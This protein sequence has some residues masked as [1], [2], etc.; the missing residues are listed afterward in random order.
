M[1]SPQI[2]V[3]HRRLHRLGP[4]LLTLLLLAGC[5]SVEVDA[6]DLTSP[7]LETPLDGQT[8]RVGTTIT[9]SWQAVAGASRYECQVRQSDDDGKSVTTEYTDQT[10]VQLTFNVPGFYSWRV[11]AM[12]AEDE[13]GYWSEIWSIRVQ[14]QSDN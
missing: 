3:P 1:K 6:P 9:L 12:N 11:R 13:S 5:D 4:V 8:V 2:H 7:L 10:T 14:G